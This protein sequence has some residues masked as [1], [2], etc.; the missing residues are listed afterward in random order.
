M[1]RISS[2]GPTHPPKWSG[3]IHEQEP[4]E[5][6]FIYYINKEVLEEAKKSRHVRQEGL[7]IP[8]LI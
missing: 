3:E 4:T 5:Y 7:E 6:C 2:Y 1:G 8:T